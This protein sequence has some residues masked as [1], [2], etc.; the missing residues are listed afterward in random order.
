MERIPEANDPD[1]QLRILEF[2]M[3]L[4]SAKH[5]REIRF[6]QS[7]L[8][9]LMGFLI[10]FYSPSFSGRVKCVLS[11]EVIGPFIVV[12]VALLVICI[13]IILGQY[14]GKEWKARSKVINVVRHE[15]AS[16]QSIPAD[17]F[18]ELLDNILPRES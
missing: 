7:L 13:T 15:M 10:G 18:Q 11:Q 3:Q 2:A 5:E 4:H 16:R 14:E 17:R 8:I 9:A 6:L 1:W 12:F